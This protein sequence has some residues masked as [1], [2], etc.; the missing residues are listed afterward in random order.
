MLLCDASYTHIATLI[1]AVG[2]T[3]DLDAVLAAGMNE[4]EGVVDRI[5]IHH[6]TYM[7]NTMTGARTG[8][9]HQVARA[10]LF[11]LDGNVAGILVAGGTA[12]GNVVLSI[13]IAGET[14]AVEGVGTLAATAVAGTNQRRGLLKDIFYVG[15]A[16]LGIIVI[17]IEEIE[18]LDFFVLLC[19]NDLSGLFLSALG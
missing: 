7:A 19:T 13:D 3:A 16:N 2:R 5:D 11:T 18:I 10:H 6:D 9:E 8:E 15:E 17:L 12:N 4:S 14:R 1:V